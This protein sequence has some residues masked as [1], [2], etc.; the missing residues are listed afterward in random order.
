[1]NDKQNWGK[2]CWE[3]FRA[4]VEHRKKGH[5]PFYSFQNGSYI[6]HGVLGSREASNTE[7]AK[8]YIEGYKNS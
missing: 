1:M 8:G 6:F 4:G 2:D 3:G 5:E 7:Y